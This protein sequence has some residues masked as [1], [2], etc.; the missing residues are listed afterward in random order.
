MTRGG[1]EELCVLKYQSSL[2]WE[3]CSGVEQLIITYLS[4]T[5]ADIIKNTELVDEL[6]VWLLID[7]R[8]RR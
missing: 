8:N 6:Y 7:E 5:E 3:T 1:F 2:S 4:L